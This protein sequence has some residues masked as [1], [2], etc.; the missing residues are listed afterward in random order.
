MS[1][2]FDVET[3]ISESK[4]ISEASYIGLAD[5]VEEKEYARLL[6]LDSQDRGVELKRLAESHG[7]NYLGNNIKTGLPV[8]K[9]RN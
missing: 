7:L 1:D 6:K 5:L 2:I 8:F 4:D 3:D 9:E